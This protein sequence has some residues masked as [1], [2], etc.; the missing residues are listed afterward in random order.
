MVLDVNVKNKISYPVSLCLLLIIL[1]GCTTPEATPLASLEPASQL[2]TVE[3]MVFPE[4]TESP[5]CSIPYFEPV[6]L[7]PDGNRLLVKDQQKIFIVDVNT[8]KQGGSFENPI[9]PNSVVALSPDGSLLAFTNQQDNTIELIDMTDGST[10]NTLL[11]HTG[12]ITD[13]KFA[14]NSDKL[15]TSSHDTWVR[16]WDRQ[17]N[18]VSSFQPTGADDFPSEVL[19]MAISSDGT[20][21]ATIPFT[22]PV[23]IWNTETYVEIA[24]MGGGG[25]YDTS[26]VAF[27]ADGKYLVSDLATGLWLWRVSDGSLVL[28][29]INTMAFAFSP[30]GQEIAYVDIDQNWNVKLVS[31]D[32]MQELGTL[33][34]NNEWLI[35][36]VDD[37]RL[38][39]TNGEDTRVW[40]LGEENYIV[41]RSDR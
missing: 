25:G 34:G 8:W 39:S 32:S 38:I 28:N 30:D 5:P 17:G 7:F 11:G 3:E 13:L 12:L 14:P 16:V 26:D 19:G 29:S 22:G 1:T 37:T 2:P 9:P 35:F 6:A 36:F 4:V 27:S 33:T 31:L 23:K 18:P 20:M 40:Q 21:L 15:L 24:V 41:C 10:V